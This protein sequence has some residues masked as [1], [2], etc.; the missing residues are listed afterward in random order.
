M[1]FT[2]ILAA[3]AA[4]AGTATAAIA[5]RNNVVL[6]WGQGPRQGRLRDYCEQGV[7]NI[8]NIGFMDVFPED[9]NGYGGTNFGNMCWNPAAGYV[10]EGPGFVN[11][12]GSRTIDRS[13]NKLLSRCPTIAGDIQYCQVCCTIYL[14]QHL[15]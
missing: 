12:D 11:P 9:G 3:A 14:A 1:R 6:Y 15:D 7:A 10:F 2:S 4:F 13:K 5:D 8:I